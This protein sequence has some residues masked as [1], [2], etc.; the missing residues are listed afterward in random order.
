MLADIFLEHERD[1]ETGWDIGWDRDL[2]IHERPFSC[3]AIAF[4]K[5]LN[6]VNFL[7]ELHPCFRKFQI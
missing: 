6:F 2:N 7:D 3:K 5:G 4:W 1:C